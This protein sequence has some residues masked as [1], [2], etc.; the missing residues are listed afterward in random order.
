MLVTVD[1]GGTK[2]LV[3]SFSEDGSVIKS[4]KFPTPRNSVEYIDLLSTTIR[5][6]SDHETIEAIV[7]GGLEVV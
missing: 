3:A 1:T 2:T 4:V 7:V 6:I 5:S